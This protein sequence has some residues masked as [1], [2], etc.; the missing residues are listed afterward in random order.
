V[1]TRF[2]SRQV[3]YVL[4][5][6]DQLDNSQF[7]TSCPA[8]AQGMHLFGDASG[9]IGGRRERG[10]IFWN[11]ALRFGANHTLAIVPNCGHNENFCMFT[12]QVMI[13]AIM[14]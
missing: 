8:N 10:T 9:F 3:A 11:Y 12:D 2:L 13:D 6:K 5:E 7:D 14:F 4:G 1:K